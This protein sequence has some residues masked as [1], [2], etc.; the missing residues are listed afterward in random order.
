MAVP[1]AELFVTVGADIAGFTS[2]MASVSQ[3]I[4]RAGANLSSVGMDLTKGITAP[5]VAVG[6]AIGGTGADFE[7]AFTKVRKTVDLTG[8]D[9][10]KLRAGLINLST[11]NIGGGKSASELAS[12]ASVAGQLGI[13]GADNLLK[14]TQLAA[15]MSVATGISADSIGEDLTRIAILTKTPSSA[16]ENMASTIVGLG[17]DM[18]GSEADIIELAKRLSGALATVGVSP[19]DIL[20]ISSALAALGVNAEAGGTAISKFFLEMVS[21]SSGAGAVNEKTATQIQNLQDRLQDLGAQ[22]QSAT[23]KQQQFGRNTPA[24]QIQQ[25][26]SDIERYKR[27]IGQAQTSLAK[28]QGTA[29][30]GGVAGFAKVAGVTADQFKEMVKTDPSKAFQAIVS[31]LARINSEKGPEGVVAALKD[32]GVDDARMTDT[33]LRLSTGEATLAKGIAVANSAWAENKALQ[34]EVTKAMD[35]PINQFNL[36]VNQLNALAIKAWPSLSKVMAETLALI[37][38]QLIPFLQGLLQAWLN[39]SPEMQRT[40]VIFAAVAAAIGPAIFVLGILLTALGALLTPIGL[41]VTAV[42]FLATAWALNLGDIQGKTKAVVDFITTN[43]RTLISLIPGLGPALIGIVDNFDTIKAGVGRFLSVIANNFVF[44]VTFAERALR[45]VGAFFNKY[46]LPPIQAVGSWITEHI[47]TPLIGLLKFLQTL[48]AN[49]GLGAALGGLDIEGAIRGAELA[50]ASA[51]QGIAA[52]G[53]G[54]ANNVVVN[55]NNPAVPDMTVG[56]QFA[57]QVQNALIDALIGSER[58]VQLPAPSLVPGQPF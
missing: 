31:G 46:L 14:F 50:T 24:A 41:L 58:T 5:I 1:I 22:L 42:A 20:G 25:T 45:E 8:A 56:E 23:T 57:Q 18:A 30:G 54:T 29:A 44:L 51:S 43:W 47:L 10:D 34:T 39:L 27:E 40:V 19:Q 4:Q 12:I 3:Q 32:I 21:A 13:E 28:L 37:R 26:A 35:D 6:A 16:W 55:I 9:L 52:G 33:L 17:N 11:Q 2:G 53:P 49:T 15:G 7:H 48:I 36:L 38:A